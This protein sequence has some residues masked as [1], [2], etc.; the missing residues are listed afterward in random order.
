MAKK[1]KEF[2]KQTV[3]KNTTVEDVLQ[4]VYED[5]QENKDNINAFIIKAIEII[6]EDSDKLLMFTKNV[7]DLVSTGLKNTDML[8]KSIE[9]I[10]RATQET[11]VGKSKE[12]EDGEETVKVDLKAMLKSVKN[13]ATA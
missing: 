13:I 7:N 11:G 12:E 8:M 5:V 2:L 10:R 4:V 1:E 9:V 6:G 3:F